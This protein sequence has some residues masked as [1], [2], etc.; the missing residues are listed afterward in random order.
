MSLSAKYQR[1]LAGPSSGTLADNASLHY[2]TTLTSIKTPTDI[3]KHFSTQDKVLKKKSEKVL[4]VI[5]GDNSLALDVEVTIEFI[6]GG[7]AYLPGLDQEFL[8]DRMATLPVVRLLSMPFSLD[9]C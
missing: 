8:S 1:F 4:N 6:A 3:I 5:E 9:T 7:G 2:I